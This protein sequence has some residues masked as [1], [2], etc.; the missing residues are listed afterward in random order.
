MPDERL[1][2]NR[3]PRADERVALDFRPSPH[4][5]IRLNFHERPD[6]RLLANLAA[7]KI[8]E[9][10]QTDVLPELDARRDA[11]G[12]ISHEV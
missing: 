12:G 8:R 7:V 1:F 11:K 2:A 9:A 10:N 3:H 4:P 5:Y 6:E